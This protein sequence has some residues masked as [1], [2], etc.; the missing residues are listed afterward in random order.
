M[1]MICKLKCQ[2]SLTEK[3]VERIV[4]RFNT[5]VK[6]EGLELA[7]MK[8]GLEILF[9]NINK[10]VIVFLIA[11]H[12]NILKEALFMIFIFGSIRSTAFGLHAKSSVV[13]TLITS[14]MFVVGP[15]VSY[16]IKLDNYVVLVVFIIMTFCFYKYA[17]ADTER[18]PILGE[19]LRLKLRKKTVSKSLFFMVITLIVKIQVIKAMIV[20]AI[21]F[22]VISILPIIYKILNR[23]YN[24]YEEYEKTNY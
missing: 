6:K 15:Y 13:C 23:R 20:L 22:N 1:E 4:M 9:I 21:G 10:M 24:N 12:F 5:K 11:S 17:P 19:K 14:M 2:K 16:H 3:L 18:H 8:L 7:K